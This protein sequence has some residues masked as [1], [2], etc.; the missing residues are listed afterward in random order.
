VTLVLFAFAPGEELS[1]HTSARPAIVH[2]LEG[3]VELSAGDDRFAGAAGTWFRMPA[4]MP[5]SVRA[6]TPVRMALTLLPPGG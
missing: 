1:E 2:I 3:E 4:G 5:H 6:R